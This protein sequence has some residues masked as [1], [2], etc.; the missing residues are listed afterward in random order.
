MLRA[1][2]PVFYWCSLVPTAISTVVWLKP[3]R[4]TR[5]FC[6]CTLWCPSALPHSRLHHPCGCELLSADVH[7]DPRP[8]RVHSCSLTITLSGDWCPAV[9][10]TRR[11]LASAVVPARHTSGTEGCSVP[12]PK[13]FPCSLG[14]RTAISM[15]RQPRPTAGWDKA[16]KECTGPGRIWFRSCALPAHKRNEDVREKYCLPH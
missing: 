5:G 6:C 2:F 13:G 15:A 4:A 3:L 16:S 9:V 10:A 14:S 12:G 8:E 7:S 11:D 1:V